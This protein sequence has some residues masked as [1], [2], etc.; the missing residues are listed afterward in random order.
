MSFAFKKFGFFQQQELPSLGPVHATCYAAGSTHL[1][2]GC[3]NGSVQALN[4][5]AQ[6]AFSFTAHGSKVFHAVWIEVRDAMNA[7]PLSRSH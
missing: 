2:A 1:F 5:R 6:A 4:E 3:D 7:D